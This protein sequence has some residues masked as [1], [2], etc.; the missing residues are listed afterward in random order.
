MPT[1]GGLARAL[2]N[3]RDIGCTAVQVFTSNPQQWRGRRITDEEAEAFESAKRSTG[4]KAVISH[5]CYL[6]NLAAPRAELRAKSLKSLTEELERSAKLK[7]PY[8][9]SHMGAHLGE[10]EKLGLKRLSEGVARLLQSTPKT[11][12]L[13]LETTAGQGTTLGYRFEH[14]AY[15]LNENHGHPR[16]AVCLDTCHLFAS[17]YDLRT[18]E[19]YES[20]MEEFDSVIGIDRLK[21]IHLNDSLKPLGSRVDRHAHIGKG[22]IGLEAFRLIVN[23]PRLRGIPMVVETP[24]ADKK[25]RE[26]VQTLWSLIKIKTRRRRR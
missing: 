13:A 11:V 25:H 24:E 15:V 14:L 20:T 1:S 26:N 16:L 6:T 23:D 22:E 12:S 9:V 8:V 5:D 2:Y 3:G 7:I 21:V 19:A 4:I 17:G 18:R 10:G